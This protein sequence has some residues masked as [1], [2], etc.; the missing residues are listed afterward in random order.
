M[1]LQ[2]TIRKR[3]EVRGI[4]IH[5]G[6]PCT[7]SFRPAPPDTGVYFVRADLPGRPA[8]R[9]SA[10]AVEAT[11]LQTTIAGAN[12][13]VA[14][15]EHCLC[16]LSALRIDNLF[17]ELDGPEIPICDGSARDFCEALLKV[18][19]VEQDQPRKY[20]YITE[21][22]YFSE[23]DKHAYV[24]PY[25]GLRLTVTIDFPHPAIGKQKL[26]LDINE[27][28]FSREL[29]AARTFGFV[30]DVETLQARGLAKGAS[31]ANAIGLDEKGVVNP[32]GLRWPD[33]FVRHKGL[34]AL[35]DLTTLEMPLMGHV[36]LYKAGHD[37]M[38]KLVRKIMDTP[39]SFRHV[40]LG[41]DVSAE[42]RRYAGWTPGGA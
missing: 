4:G 22:I 33:E 38:N 8:L 35:G 12:F 18:G 25:H 9:V 37:L 41:A 24:V 2:K 21:P 23:G 6:N 13:S 3:T 20:C 5:S 36:I 29:A 40:E 19:M 7:L 17:I 15:I 27:H 39:Q 1:F 42:V 14:T 34:D 28:T 30:R 16:A 11:T 26:D 10:R 31:L 32:E